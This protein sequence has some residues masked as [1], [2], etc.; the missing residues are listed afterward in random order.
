MEGDIHGGVQIRCREGAF[1]YLIEVHRPLNCPN[2]Y[3]V[4]V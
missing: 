4:I 3:A 2:Q 1:R